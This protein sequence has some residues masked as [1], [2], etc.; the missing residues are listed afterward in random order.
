MPTQLPIPNGV[1]ACFSPRWRLHR[2]HAAQR[3]QPAVEALSRRHRLAH[4]GLQ[5]QEPRRR[6][7][8]ATRRTA[9][10]TSTR[11]WIGDTVYFRS[12]RNGEYNVFAYDA[13]A[14]TIK[15]LTELRRLPGPGP[16]LRRRPAH[17][18][19]GGL[20]A[21]V[22]SGER[23][24]HAAEDRRRHATSSRPG[25]ATSRGRSTSATPTCRRPGAGG[26]RVPRRD[27]HGAGREG[28][29]AQP[30]RVA[31]RPRPLA[32]LVARWQVDR[33]VLRRGRRV[34]PARPRRRRQGRGEDV[35]PQRARASTRTPPGRRMRRRSPTSTT[36]SRCTGSTWTAA[37][38][39][40]VASEPQY[41]PTGAAGSCGPRG[42]RTRSGSPTRWA[43]RR[44]TTRVYA[45]D[46]AADKSRTITDGL[47]D[48]VD[49]VFDASGKYLYFLASTD[50]GPVNQ[51]FA[52]SNADMRVQRSLYLVVLQEGR[53]VAAGPRERRGE[54]RTPRTSRR[55]RRTRRRRRRSRC[56]WSSTSTA[57]TSASL[58]LPMPAGNYRNLQAG[59]A[60]QVFYLEAPAACRRAGRSAAAAR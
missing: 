1:E 13:V 26:V 14:K 40:K 20:S 25:R 28:R 9:A 56:R 10:T 4:L 24:R 42:R 58:P 54:G 2:L 18:R 12:D 44:R 49:P 19:A 53:A 3:P 60:G 33:L 51:W 59:T 39:T 7:D 27:R 21:P 32:G 23:R 50:A 43:T 16:R 8:P 35:R 55:T 45:Y 47:S 57:S 5:R 15:Q 30:D 29:P 31:R 17:L 41:G 37:R 52:Q 22:R 11:N 6:A 46:L 34:P 38:S 48:A 36:R